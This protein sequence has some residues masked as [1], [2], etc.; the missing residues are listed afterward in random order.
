MDLVTLNRSRPEVRQMGL[1][2][3]PRVG[4]AQGGEG[5]NGATSWVVCGVG[6]IARPSPQFAVAAVGGLVRRD[7]LARLWASCRM[8]MVLHIMPKRVSAHYA[9]IMLEACAHCMPLL[10]RK[11]LNAARSA[12]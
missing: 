2:M 10:C 7:V 8:P 9:A 5:G 6:A 1:M 12:S 11:F 3:P 4:G